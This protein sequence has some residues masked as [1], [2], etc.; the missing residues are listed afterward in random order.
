M[1]LIQINLIMK[2]LLEYWIIN[3]LFFS[4]LGWTPLHEAASEGC[5]D[6][7]VELLKASAN[8]NCENVDGILPLHDAVAN[9]HLKV[10][11]TSDSVPITFS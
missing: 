6:V 7:I 3:S 5:N 1:S 2:I 4:F 11:C 9:S 10:Q 8:V